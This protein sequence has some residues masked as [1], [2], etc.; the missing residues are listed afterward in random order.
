MECK[1]C[2]KEIVFIELDSVELYENDEFVS[3]EF[4]CKNCCENYSQSVYSKNFL[5]DLDIP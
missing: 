2:K 3:V 1:N 5:C 4:S